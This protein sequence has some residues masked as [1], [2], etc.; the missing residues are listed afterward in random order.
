[1]GPSKVKTF[2]L[3]H[4]IETGSGDHPASS[5]RARVWSDHS[6]PASALVKK[7]WI[8]KYTLIAQGKLYLS[9]RST[10]CLCS[11]SSI[12]SPVIPR[13][14]LGQYLDTM[15]QPL[16]STSFLIHNSLSYHSTLFVLVA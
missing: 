15:L 13:Q 10:D 14:M 8:Y 9:E 1:M 11:F 16:S 5:M 7:T 6:A 4:I 3:L 2:S 12:P